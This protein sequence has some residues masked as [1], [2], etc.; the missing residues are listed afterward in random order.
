MLRERGFQLDEPVTA[1]GDDADI[2]RDFLAA[3]E[4]PPQ[5]RRAAPIP[6]TSRSRSKT[7]ARSTTTSRR[8]APRRNDECGVDANGPTSVGRADPRARQG[9]W[10]MGENPAARDEEVRALRLGLDLGLTL[11]D[12]AEMYADG[13]RRG[14]RRRSDRGT[15]G[16]GLPR[17]Q[18]PARRTRRVAGRSRRASAASSGC[19][20]TGSTSTSCTGAGELPLADT[21]EAF[22]ELK[23]AG[24]DPPLGRQQLRRSRPCRA[25]RR[26]RRRRG[27]DRPGAL[28]P[29][30]PAG[31]STNCCR[32][33][34]TG[35]LPLMA[36]SPVDR[37]ALVRETTSS[38]R[39]RE[40]RR[41]ARA[42]RARVG[43]SA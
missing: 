42:G 28:Q 40:A 21:V 23:Q 9:T 1:E 11:I 10:R 24:Q 3:R 25:D 35:G 26:R 2:L 41:H 31:T 15:P 4:S 8:T 19:A 37:G 36:Y 30:P 18:G 29:L 12:T 17:Q 16:R 43:A 13:A 20:P 38:S 32:G 5:P 6:K 39:S 22:T 34:A 33:A 14:A 27:R 7:F